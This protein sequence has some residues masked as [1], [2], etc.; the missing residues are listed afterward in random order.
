MLILSPIQVIEVLVRAEQG[1]FRE[2]V[3]H[4]NHVEEQVVERLA[5]DSRS[6][7][8]DSLRNAKDKVPTCQEVRKQ[9]L[10]HSL[11]YALA[12]SQILSTKGLLWTAFVD[13]KY[14]KYICT[15]TLFYV[16]IITM[17]YDL[18]HN[19]RIIYF[20][21]WNLGYEYI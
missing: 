12:H 2:V 16:V 11:T 13:Y 21:F 10:T 20:C 19:S 8:W 7:L 15:P 6:P 4:L 9:S 5:W 18:M 14:K 1:L 3:K 17:L